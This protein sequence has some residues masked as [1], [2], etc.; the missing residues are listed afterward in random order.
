MPGSLQV[1]TCTPKLKIV[2]DKYQNNNVPSPPDASVGTGKLRRLTRTVKVAILFTPR[3]DYA[4][5]TLFK[6]NQY[7]VRRL[8]MELHLLEDIWERNVPLGKEWI[9]K[10]L[11]DWKRTITPRERNHYLCYNYLERNDEWYLVE[12]TALEEGTQKYMTRIVWGVFAVLCYGS[13]AYYLVG[14]S[15]VLWGCLCVVFWLGKLVPK[16][17]R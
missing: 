1:G 6:E 9:E 7:P 5:G 16:R 15:N 17:F 13:V 8:T 3:R 2:H 12:S 14:T 10:K 4:T 11:K